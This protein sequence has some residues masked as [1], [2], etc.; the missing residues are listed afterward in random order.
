MKIE[1]ILKKVENPLSDEIILEILKCYCDSKLESSNSKN[2]DLYTKIVN[3]SESTSKKINEEDRKKY[4]A[5]MFSIWKKNILSLTE[6]EI[7]KLKSAGKYDDDIY[8]LRSYLKD[9]PSELTLEQIDKIGNN[10]IANKYG[11]MK[12]NKEWIRINS[13]KISANTTIMPYP[14][15][16]LYLSIDLQDIYM[17]AALFTYKCQQH[18][19]PYLFKFTKEKE[20]YDSFVIHTSSDYLLEYLEILEEIKEER[21]DIIDR[22]KKL[23]LLV[24]KINN[25]IGYG[26]EPLQNKLNKGNEISYNEL[27]S[28][29][30]EEAIKEI[31]KELI[32]SDRKQVIN[33]NGTIIPLEDYVALEY[34][35]LSYE[36]GM[37]FGIDGYTKEQI[38]EEQFKKKMFQTFKEHKEEIINN[39]DFSI[40]PFY[41]PNVI[42]KEKINAKVILKLMENDKYINNLKE[43]IKKKCKY[44]GIDP[45]NFALNKEITKDISSINKEEFSKTKDLLEEKIAEKAKEEYMLY[46][47]DLERL[48]KYIDREQYNKFIKESKENDLLSYFGKLYRE[49]LEKID[50]LKRRHKVIEKKTLEDLNKEPILLK[51]FKELYKN[52]IDELKKLKNLYE[53]L[54]KDGTEEVI[55]EPTPLP[56]LEDIEELK[57]NY[58]I[59]KDNSTGKNVIK[60]IKTGQIETNSIQINNVMFAYLWTKS[61]GIKEFINDTDGYAF[62]D[63][64]RKTYEYFWNKVILSLKTTGKL[65]S[66]ELY[67]GSQLLDYK[68][69]T[70]II[71]Q[72]L[73]NKYTIKLIEMLLKDRNQVQEG[74]LDNTELLLGDIYYAESL[75]NTNN[76]NE[77]NLKTENK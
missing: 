46:I 72:L 27:R 68:Y 2:I 35:L 42:E 16:R 67:K 52:Y 76:E 32:L 12:S 18:K 37:N 71:V 19:I 59:E 73:K 43:S 48:K 65:D 45:D 1:D 22:C 13:S 58:V 66:I 36:H 56:S 54:N 51:T 23:P 69:A 34:F 40:E 77:I 28:K 33:Y 26:E 17:M 10:A 7:K 11:W 14:K 49:Y 9:I 44:Y 60:N 75:I 31:T 39:K 55:E 5:I 24:G 21:K 70:L 25:F 61:A 63:G 47:R 57:K 62:N 3:I 4:I 15:H 29:V 64:A 20:R 74:A 6:E 50:E 38:S 30:L 41:K 53:N 8:Q